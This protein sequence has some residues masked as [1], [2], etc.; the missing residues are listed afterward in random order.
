MSTFEFKRQN[1]QNFFIEGHLT[2]TSLNKKKI[3]SIN[4]LNINNNITIDL[5]KVSSSDS[6]GL[7]VLI[8]WIKQSKHANFKLLFKNT[9]HQLLTLAKLS[10][11]DLDEYLID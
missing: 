8:E 4:L 9:P 5:A 7:A 2:I 11:V 6:A 3:A 10:G 1:D